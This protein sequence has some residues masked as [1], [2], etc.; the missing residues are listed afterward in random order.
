MIKNYNAFIN[1]DSLAVSYK[2]KVI[3]KNLQIKLNLTNPRKS[4]LFIPDKI[5]EENDILISFKREPQINPYINEINEVLLTIRESSEI[6]TFYLKVSISTMVNGPDP[7]FEPEKGIEI[8]YT[9]GEEKAK[10]TN[11]YEKNLFFCSAYFDEPP[12]DDPIVISKS[13]ELSVGHLHIFPLFHNSGSC[14]LNEKG[15]YINVLRHYVYNY[16]D[17][18]FSVAIGKNPYD[19]I[20]QNFEGNKKNE[21]IRVALRNERKYPEM[22]RSFGWCTWD[23]FSHGVNSEKIYQKLDEFKEKGIKV[24]WILID[25]GW[26]ETTENHPVEP[27]RLISFKEDRR[28]FPEGLKNCIKRIKEEYGVKYV[29]M[30]QAF[31]GHWKGI[32]SQSSLLSEYPDAFTKTFN[33]RF[34]PAFDY[35]GAYTFWSNREKYLKEQ[36]VDFVKV[37][38]QSGFNRKFISENVGLYEGLK[39]QYEALERAIF[40]NFDGAVINCMGGMIENC[41]SRPKTAINRNSDDFFPKKEDSFASHCIQNVYNASIFGM[42]NYCDFDMWWSKH[43]S[44]K[45]SSVLRAISGGPVYISDALGGSAI[46]FIEPIYDEEGIVYALD[47]IAKPTLDCYYTDCIKEHKTLKVFNKKGPNFVV[48]AFGLSE[49]LSKSKLSVFDLGTEGEYLAEE[50]FSGELRILNNNTEIEINLNKDE[51]VLY[52]I[53]PIEDDSIVLMGRR[54]KYIGIATEKTRSVNIADAI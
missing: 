28:K 45:Q 26:A 46:E 9:L 20:A 29:G 53:Y 10:T 39:S 50:Y 1:A 41:L 47:D 22:F 11:I 48:A 31:L 16:N 4:I 44:A 6:L 54:D 2:N 32:Y 42:I 51:V 3:L 18:V 21:L 43:V 33:E 34:I 14:K 40:E 17:A 36:G 25:D 8:N 35:E 19:A 27:A 7:M 5:V 15:A 52:N 38:V 12:T 49:G 24:S 23:A 37:D 30:W 13:A